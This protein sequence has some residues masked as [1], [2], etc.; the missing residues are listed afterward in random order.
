MV[1]Q[2]QWYGNGKAIVAKVFTVCYNLQRDDLKQ[3]YAAVCPHYRVW[4]GWLLQDGH[5]DLCISWGGTSKLCSEMW[6]YLAY[7]IGLVNCYIIICNA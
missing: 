6:T 2:W 5:S 7:N 4:F 3:W 1:L